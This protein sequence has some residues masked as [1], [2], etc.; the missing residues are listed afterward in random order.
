MLAHRRP[1][2][3]NDRGSCKRL[4]DILDQI[5]AD[6]GGADMISE[7]QRRLCRRAATLSI[8]AEAMECD[9]FGNQPFNIELYGQF[10]NRLRRHL[11][12]FLAELSAGRFVI[13]AKLFLP[14]GGEHG[15]WSRYIALDL[16][17]AHPDH[18]SAGVVL[19][20]LGTRGR[21]NDQ[22][23]QRQSIGRRDSKSWPSM[24]PNHRMKAMQHRGSK[25]E[26]EP[27]GATG[28]E[29]FRGGLSEADSPVL[30][31]VARGKDA[32]SAVTEE[33]ARDRD[34]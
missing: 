14:N 3:H 32:I 13:W 11:Q 25:P 23:L 26:S 5:V 33:G 4:K 31:S 30:D 16:G 27:F 34:V 22:G 10:Y 24:S 19:A 9:A 6:L 8:Q 18:H 28:D 15:L 21:V 1:A 12:R 29:N 17:R 2:G 7:G 20:Q